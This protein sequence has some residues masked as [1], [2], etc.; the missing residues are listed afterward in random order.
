MWVPPS[1]GLYNW[2]SSLYMKQVWKDFSFKN[3]R[4]KRHKMR[5]IF[6]FPKP[7]K[8]VLVYQNGYFLPGKSISRREKIRQNDF[9]P[10]E[11]YSS[12]APAIMQFVCVWGGGLKEGV[13]RSVQNENEYLPNMFSG[14]SSSIGQGIQ[15]GPW[16]RNFVSLM[17]VFFSSTYFRPSG[18]AQQKLG[19]WNVSSGSVW[20]WRMCDVKF[21]KPNRT[22][23]CARHAYW[24]A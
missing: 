13:G 3:G 11:K 22:I 24:C 18:A 16:Q 19:F 1:L 7:L 6:F 10:S 9:A 5:R 8:C 4:R 14:R 23:C 20:K 2:W 15:T 17:P 21:R 12:Y